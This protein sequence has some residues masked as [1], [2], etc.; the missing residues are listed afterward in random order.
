MPPGS[1]LQLW[2]QEWHLLTVARGQ[3]Q[4]VSAV[5]DRLRQLGLKSLALHDNCLL[6]H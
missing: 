3:H 6:M 1:R 2:P 5:Q 4:Q